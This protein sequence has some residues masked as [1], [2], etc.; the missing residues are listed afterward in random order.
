MNVFSGVARGVAGVAEATPIFQFLFNR[1][2]QKISVKK[3]YLLQ[4]TPISKTYLP[5]WVM[6]SDKKKFWW[7]GTSSM[8]NGNDGLSSTSKNDPSNLATR[9]KEN[10][11]LR[12]VIYCRNLRSNL[13][14]N[15]GVEFY[16][17]KLLISSRNHGVECTSNVDRIR[18]PTVHTKAECNIWAKRDIWPIFKWN[19][20]RNFV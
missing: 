19:I 1:F 3:S 4:A 2:G 10:Y 11:P 5:P 16:L 12:L 7:F 14:R 18:V 20:L 8:Y 17:A 13:R 15:Y 6:V 9:N